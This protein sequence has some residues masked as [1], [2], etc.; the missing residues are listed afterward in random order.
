MVV[1]AATDHV[2]GI[3][4][5]RPD[6]TE[7]RN[8]AAVTHVIRNGL[9]SKAHTGDLVYSHDAHVKRIRQPF[10][11]S[12]DGEQELRALETLVMSVFVPHHPVKAID[13]QQLETT[14]SAKLWYT[15]VLRKGCKR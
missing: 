3:H 2:A 10:E 6:E 4:A 5:V 11:L 7:S 1:V 9:V 14:C 12:R 15:T 13:D 8:T